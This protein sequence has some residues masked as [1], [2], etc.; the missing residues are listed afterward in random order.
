MRLHTYNF[1]KV[2]FQVQLRARNWLKL[3]TCGRIF[4]NEVRIVFDSGHATRFSRQFWKFHQTCHQQKFSLNCKHIRQVRSWHWFSP[5]CGCYVFFLVN[6]RTP[7][8]WALC[9]KCGP[10]RV[11]EWQQSTLLI[12]LNCWLTV[13]TEDVGLIVKVAVNYYGVNKHSLV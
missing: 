4:L 9:S 11:T 5:L 1:H 7:G 10:L 3:E 12:Y 13:L 6:E 2:P 8:S